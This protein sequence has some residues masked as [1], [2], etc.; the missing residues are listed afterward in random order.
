MKSSVI[1]FRQG[2]RELTT[3]RKVTLTF[4]VICLLAGFILLLQIIPKTPP[5]T[6]L[7]PPPTNAPVIGPKSGEVAAPA[8]TDVAALPPAIPVMDQSPSLTPLGSA[9]PQPA[10]EIILP[11]PPSGDY[12]L[13][14][15]AEQISAIVEKRYGGLFQFLGLPPEQL[16]RLR[17][18]L[19]ERQQATVDA[20]NAALLNGLNP[21]RELPTIRSAIEEAQAS[22]DTILRHELGEPVFAACRDYDRTLDERNS[23]GDLALLLA[24]T[25]DPLQPEQ[26]K[27]VV[28][29]LKNFPGKDT[30]MDV[31]RAIFGGIN[32]R[33]Q[34]SE[35]AMTE[36]ATVLSPRQLELLRQLQRHGAAEDTRR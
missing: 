12:E 23:A 14:L 9:V 4:A 6:T 8:E 32:T 22:I 36:A 34:I 11:P 7:V 3:A 15:T 28:Q 21:V 5:E 25:G 18:L 10:V 35:Q 17:S 16:S 27:Q 26:E 33:A 30:P 1:I 29:I 24:A 19:A 31:G 20:A 2:L 13:N